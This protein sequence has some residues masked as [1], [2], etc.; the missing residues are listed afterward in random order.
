MPPFILVFLRC[1]LMA[2]CCFRGTSQAPLFLGRDSE[3]WLSA[4]RANSK[5][6]SMHFRGDL[7]EGLPLLLWWVDQ[8]DEDALS[9][10]S[11]LVY[12]LG[13]DAAGLRGAVMRRVR[14]DPSV[15]VQSWGVRMLCSMG[16]PATPE[17]EEFLAQSGTSETAAERP[18]LAAECARALAKVGGSS[19]SI[20]TRV[21]AGAP[22]SDSGAERLLLELCDASLVF[23][24]GRCVDALI[25]ELGKRTR[26]ARM[27]AAVLPRLGWRAVRRLETS[28]HHDLA[29]AALVIGPL[30]DSF[31]R[32]GW[33]VVPGPP[34]TA[35]PRI[36]HLHC[37]WLCYGALQIYRATPY[38]DGLQLERFD[39]W[40]PTRGRGLPAE[41]VQYAYVSREDAATV[42]RQIAAIQST[43]VRVVPGGVMD[44][45]FSS[46]SRGGDCFARVSWAWGAQADKVQERRYHGIPS[47]REFPE[48]FH[49]EALARVVEQLARG[50]RWRVRRATI[51]DCL[52]VLARSTEE[53][54]DAELHREYRD[55]YCK[56]LM[57]ASAWR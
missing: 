6:V 15:W 25:R 2:L 33:E 36:A 49:A 55:F 42:A 1:V 37:D 45:G 8:G 34:S 41:V 27:A 53:S 52:W 16:L 50:C 9:A 10:T 31:L 47:D 56:V 39:L 19:E 30:E 17:E 29:A 26:A 22:A 28:G 46:D 51:E 43:E 48:R 5:R 32:E 18:P 20:L 3:Y 24:D 40:L 54:G 14:R 35:E 44:V 4:A 57:A 7:R 13:M 38:G 23:G 21:N 12:E 11:S